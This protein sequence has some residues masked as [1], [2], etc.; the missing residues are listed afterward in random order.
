MK[1][2]ENTNNIILRRVQQHELFALQDIA[3]KTFFE[4]FSAF[5]T[6]EDMQ[7]YLDETLSL[8]KLEAEFRNEHSRFYF[9]LHGGTIA[10]YLKLN[11]AEAQNEMHNENAI[12]I[13][14]IYVLEEFQRNKIGQALLDMTLQIAKAENKDVLWLGV[15]EKNTKAIRFYLKNGFTAFGSH[16]FILGSDAQNDIL[17][18]RK[19]TAD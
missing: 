10:A 8:K 4:S 17:M 7:C 13:E 11:F 18:K 19:L 3:R 5:N 14:R 6:K 16:V 2:A 12:E 15:W 1:K 9:A